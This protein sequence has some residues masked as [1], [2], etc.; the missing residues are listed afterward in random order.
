MSGLPVVTLP[1]AYEE[2]CILE[3]ASEEKHDYDA[4]TVISM[5]GGSVTHT[6]IITN[7]NGA[8]WTRLRGRACEA[9]DSTF[10][11]AFPGRT[12]THYPDGMIVCGETEI[13]PRDPTGQNL[14]NP[15]VVFEVQSPTTALFD[16]TIKFDRYR[17]L[18]S[19]REYVLVFQDH[20]EVQTFFKQA[21]GT[22]LFQTFTGLTGHVPLRSVDIALPLAEIY[23]RVTFE[24]LPADATPTR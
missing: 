16:R 1:V 9:M 22:W 7:V 14:T 24:A 17:L 20:P 19:F 12:Y 2:Y 10:R 6:R 15:T 13:D 5:P 11:I 21:D 3:A 23:D 8:A 18:D 4:G